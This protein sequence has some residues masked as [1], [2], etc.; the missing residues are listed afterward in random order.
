[1]DAWALLQSILLAV[2]TTNDPAITAGIVAVGGMA[3]GVIAVGGGAIGLIA[4]GGGAVGLF[5]RWLP[6]LGKYAG[7]PPR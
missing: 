3:L 2:Q 1:M 5:C 6:R 7:K 4:V